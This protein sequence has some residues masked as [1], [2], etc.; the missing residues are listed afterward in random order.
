MLGN[1][2]VVLSDSLQ[3][4]AANATTHLAEGL[5]AAGTPLER[6]HLSPAQR[7][8]PIREISL[9]PRLKRP[10][11]ER[12]I[13]NI[14]LPAANRLR[15][16]RHLLAFQKQLAKTQPPLLNLH[17]IHD[18][19]LNHDSIPPGIPLIWT[20][21]DR[22]PFAPEAYVWQDTNLN[23]KQFA[24]PDRPF[25]TAREKRARFFIRQAPTVLVAPSQWLA[26]EARHHAPEQIRI[27]HVPYGIDL[28]AFAPQCPTESRN[29]LQLDPKRIWIGH[30][31]TWANSRKGFDILARALN[32]VD[33]SKIGLLLWGQRP[34][35][36]LPS[37]LDTQFL[38][39]IQ[40]TK[41]LSQLYSACHLFLCP[42]R[43]DNL[44][45]TVLE[46]LAC[47]TPIIG[48]QAGGIPDMVRPTH[49]G[50]L[51]SGDIPDSCAQ[52]L[53]RAFSDQDAW[54]EFRTRC[55]KLA[56][57]EYSMQLQASRYQQLIAQLTNK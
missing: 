40:D 7:T 57:S 45:N 37:K 29:T 56:K 36:P 6:W 31:S 43:A 28:D 10:P 53:L 51:F 19:G 3:G 9:D 47:G 27:E 52:A 8:T 32:Q 12:L 17:N 34:T 39:H 25:T 30:A 26:D 16:K 20:L 55:R 50:W 44:P 2:I 41:K 42:S 48:S 54:P 14:S 24:A 46:S 35:D 15:H 4:G 49:T 21:H 11:F 5:A 22:W 18:S 38:G 1:P 23:S 13:K 33:C